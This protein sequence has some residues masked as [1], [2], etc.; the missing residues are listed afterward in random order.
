MKRPRK[1]NYRIPKYWKGI[2]STP[3]FQQTTPNT[4]SGF[5]PLG[6]VSS[7]AGSFISPLIGAIMGE[8]AEQKNARMLAKRQGELQQSTQQFNA[9]NQQFQPNIPTF[10]KGGKMKR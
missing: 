10:G 5:N 4:S 9:T 3:Q 2:G 6:M 1:V 7:L 8:S